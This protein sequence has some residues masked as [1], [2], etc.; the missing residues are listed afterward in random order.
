MNGPEIHPAVDAKKVQDQRNAEAFSDATKKAVASAT[1]LAVAYKRRMRKKA[2]ISML[3]RLAVAFALS[4]VVV[5]LRKY[6]HM[7]ADVSIA[8]IM[9]FDSWAM[10]WVGAWMQ[11]MW[12]EEGLLR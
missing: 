8:C 6:G 5:L 1:A 9:V 2:T 3:I 12:G 7:S 4:F 11:F 10:L